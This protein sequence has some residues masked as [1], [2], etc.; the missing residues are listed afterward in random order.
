[1]FLDHGHSK[2]LQHNL[3]LILFKMRVVVLQQQ[4]TIMVWLFSTYQIL[5]VKALLHPPWRWAVWKEVGH[6]RYSVEGFNDLSP[7]PS[8]S[9]SWPQWG[10]FQTSNTHLLS[11]EVWPCLW[12]KTK[13]PSTTESETEI[14]NSC[15][16]IIISGI[17]HSDKEVT[18]QTSL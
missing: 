16:Y 4:L 15:I 5:C 3:S 10:K 2:W 17:C 18:Y 9:A 8:L 14:A 13:D 11:C 7:F 1:M 12:S 6:W